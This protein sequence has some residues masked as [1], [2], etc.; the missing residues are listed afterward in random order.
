MSKPCADWITRHFMLRIHGSSV[1][2]T[3]YNIIM[4]PPDRR[5]SAI[6][7]ILRHWRTRRIEDARPKRE[8]FQGA[9]VEKLEDQPPLAQFREAGEYGEEQI[10]VYDNRGCRPCGCGF[11]FD[12]DHSKSSNHHKHDFRR[13]DQSG[14]R[15]RQQYRGASW[16]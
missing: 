10:G 15:N 1:V 3:P 9:Y 11:V 4:A 6:W 8:E 13:D 14:H 16:G 12:T 2:A 5:R 7:R